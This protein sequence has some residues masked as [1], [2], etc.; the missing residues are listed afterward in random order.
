MGSNT[1]SLKMISI[2]TDAGTLELIP[3]ATDQLRG[4]ARYWP[5]ELISMLDLPGHFGLVFQHGDK[6]VHGVKLQPPDALEA[7]AM[8][9]FQVNRVLVASAVSL[10]LAKEHKGVMVP[11]PYYKTKAPGKAET[12]IAFFVGPDGESQS[13]AQGNVRYDHELG[14][15][16]TAMIMDMIHAIG[17]AS[18]DLRIPMATVIG[19]DVRPRLA[20]GGLAMDFLVEGPR[21]FVVSDRVLEH[22][23]VWLY[24]VRAGFS[25]VPWAPMAPTEFAADSKETGR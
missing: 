11:C 6:E 12:G 17:T 20:L 21:V 15:G 24:L 4:I 3:A 1:P 13:R 16:A 9:L 23:S 25:R 14:L 10:Y 8:V 5:M 7:D 22:D 2:T 18:R 19:I